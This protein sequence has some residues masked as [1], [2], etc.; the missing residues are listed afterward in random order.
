MRLLGE[1]GDDDVEVPGGRQQVWMALSRSARMS[2]G[3]SDCTIWCST[4]GP[5]ASRK[6]NLQGAAAVALC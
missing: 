2:P 4:S 1:S 5:Q 6:A 3:T